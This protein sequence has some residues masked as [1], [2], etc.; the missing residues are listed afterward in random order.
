MSVEVSVVGIDYEN[1][2]LN[3][4]DCLGFIEFV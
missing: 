1:L 2:C 3:F 4:F